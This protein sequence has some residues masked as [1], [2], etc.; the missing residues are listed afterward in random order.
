MIALSLCWPPTLN[1]LYT[2]AHGRKILSKRGRL[3]HDEIAGECQV[4]LVGKEKP[5][6][7]MLEAWVYL[8]PPTLR[9]YD[10]DNYSKALMDGLK[11]AGVYQ[12]DYQIE[13]LHL[14]RV[15]PVP[16]G[17]VE[18]MLLPVQPLAACAQTCARWQ[19]LLCGTEVLSS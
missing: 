16:Q 1:T 12:D 18:L 10:I 6:K 15:A 7:G 9:H 19:A 13:V 5:L 8:A 4:Q 17:R 11:Y 3:Y 14:R 2:V